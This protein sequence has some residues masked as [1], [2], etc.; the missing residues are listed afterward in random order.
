MNIKYQLVLACIAF[1]IV[2]YTNGLLAVN[3][4]NAI[5]TSPPLPDIGFTYLPHIAEMYPNIL[6]VL[7][8]CYFG[9]RYVRYCNINYLTKLLWCITILFVF[10]MITFTVTTVPPS[11]I[12][13][14]N[15]NSTLPIEWNVLKVIFFKDDNTCID[16]MFSGHA[17]YFILTLIFIFDLS[18]S[19]LE[20]TLCTIYVII[21]LLSII[22]GRIHYTVD[23]VVAIIL[24]FWCYY[25]IPLSI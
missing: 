4:N 25:L 3:L 12:G 14:F 10:R 1:S 9:G 22:S 6:L 15:R 2:S 17:I 24:S 18:H 13:C 19:F 5:I 11:T 8:C 23:V 16:Y 20:K 7:F 21:G